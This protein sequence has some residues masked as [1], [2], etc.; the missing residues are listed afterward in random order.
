[1]D[2]LEQLRRENA[3]LKQ[4][5]AHARNSALEEA[6]AFCDSKRGWTYEPEHCAE[7]IRAMKSK[8]PGKPVH[9]SQYATEAFVTAARVALVSLAHAAEKHGIYQTDYD[10]FA[11]AIEKFTVSVQAEAAK[12]RPVLTV[13]EGAMPESNGKSNFT[14]T[15]TRKDLSGIASVSAG[16][17]FARS[18][19]PDRVRYEA[20]RMRYLIGEIDQKP[21]IL[22]YDA[23]KHSGY[24]YPEDKR[25]KLK[26]LSEGLP[27]PDDHHRVLVF[28]DGVDFRGEQF[29]DIKTEDLWEPEQDSRTEIVEAATHWM[30]LPRVE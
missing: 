14:A 23:D 26:P 29:F 17:T 25:M 4:T 21:F 3:E 2:E 12:L 22:D 7:D 6:A 13:W 18:E 30:E 16:F 15:L 5:L 24:V 19:Y 28:T 20:D 9:A 27:S 1:M 10:R 8:E 11:A